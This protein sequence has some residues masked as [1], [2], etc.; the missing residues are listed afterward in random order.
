MRIDEKTVTRLLITKTEG[1]SA[2]EKT[3]LKLENGKEQDM[4]KLKPRK[5][6]RLLVIRPK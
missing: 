5:W 3:K 4:K 1:K 6:K 2:Q